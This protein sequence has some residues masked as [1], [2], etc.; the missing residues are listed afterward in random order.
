MANPVYQ[1]E[2]KMSVRTVRLAMLIMVFNGILA[3]LS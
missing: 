3:A 2:V 1:K